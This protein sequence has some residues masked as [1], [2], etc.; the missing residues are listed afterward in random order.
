MS[1]EPRYRFTCCEEVAP[2]IALNKMMNADQL[3]EYYL[4]TARPGITKFDSSQVADFVLGESALIMPPQYCVAHD[5]TFKKSTEDCDDCLNMTWDPHRLSHVV[6]HKDIWENMY[7]VE[8]SPGIY[9]V[10]QKLVFLEPI[11]IIGS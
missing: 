11:S 3:P 10:F 8:I 6:L 5:V 7:V 1:K 2:M 4:F 9:K